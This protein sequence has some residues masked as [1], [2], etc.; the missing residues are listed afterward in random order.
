MKK[1]KIKFSTISGNKVV[2]L[3]GFTVVTD[4]KQ[5]G[6][7]WIKHP[8]FDQPTPLKV[9]EFYFPFSKMQNNIRIDYCGYC[10]LPDGG[11]NKRLATYFMVAADIGQ[12]LTAVPVGHNG[13]VYQNLRPFVE[14]DL[15]KFKG[16]KKRMSVQLTP[17]N[18]S[19]HEYVS[20]S[21]TSEVAMDY[22]CKEYTQLEKLFG[23]L[24]GIPLL[25]KAHGIEINTP[26]GINRTYLGS[27]SINGGIEK[28]SYLKGMNPMDGLDF[29]HIEKMYEDDLLARVTEEAAEVE[30]ESNVTP[31]HNPITGEVEEGNNVSVVTDIDLTDE[32]KKLLIT[33]LNEDE[34]KK[35]N[36]KAKALQVINK[37]KT[38]SALARA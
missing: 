22:F 38:S 37:I 12:P 16:V 4:V 29:S 3:E 11:R 26:N 8:E 24:Q 15:D 28:I 33:H 17:K 31:K 6:T 25:F 5:R 1:G 27:L 30:A 13:K 2:K 18:W 10:E 35:I 7:G 36:T 19:P 32:Q 23:S 21:T 14:E 34:L 20:W 9:M